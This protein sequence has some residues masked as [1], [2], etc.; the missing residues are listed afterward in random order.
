MSAPYCRRTS[1]GAVTLPNDLDILRPVLVVDEAM[2]QDRLE[3]GNAAGADRFQQR[4]VEPAAVLVGAFKIQ[5][6]WPGQ[7]PALQHEGMGRSGLE[8]DSTMSWTCS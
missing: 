8:P 3:R 5:I 1:S 6:G 4:R 2:R 7:M